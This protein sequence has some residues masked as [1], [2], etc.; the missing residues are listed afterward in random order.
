M[1]KL[2][3][4]LSLVAIGL[5]G[6]YIRGQDEGYRRDRDHHEDNSQQRGHDERGGERGD[7]NR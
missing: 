5:S 4:V 1:K 7:Y 2:L 3:L 6:C